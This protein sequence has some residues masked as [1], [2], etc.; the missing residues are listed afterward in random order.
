MRDDVM[1]T[2]RLRRLAV[3]GALMVALTACSS[4]G[5][6][7]GGDG[8]SVAASSPVAAA[9][10]ASGIAPSA[11]AGAT[12][13]TAT[14]AGAT[15]SSGA[16][17]AAASAAQS[18]P[19]APPS[20]TGGAAPAPATASST[21]PAPVLALAK[22]L[23]DKGLPIGADGSIPTA[24][25]PGYDPTKGQQIYLACAASLAAAQPTH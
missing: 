8:E 2:A 18:A 13:A 24:M 16:P 10:P 20:A 23:H 19:A 4:G 25:P 17:R 5:S 11:A 15:G 22:C 6:P 9:S 1:N 7:W 14:S 21:L 3:A 12:S